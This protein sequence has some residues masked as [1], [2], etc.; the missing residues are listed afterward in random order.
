MVG[1]SEII[2][3]PGLINVN[4]AND[5][6]VMQDAGTALMGIGNGSEKKT[7][8]KDTTVAGILSPL[9]D[10]PIYESLCRYWRFVESGLLIGPEY[11]WF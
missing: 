6:S 8:V 4:F 1:I 7:S 10:A 9:L 2:V 5:Q 11:R 3:Q